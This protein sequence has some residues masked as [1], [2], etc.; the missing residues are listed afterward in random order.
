MMTYRFSRG[1]TTAASALA[2]LALALPAHA[3]N[4][5]ESLGWQFRT[6]A[7]RVNQAAI[8]DLIEKRKAGSYAAPVY[9][10]TIER[11][12]N[13]GISSTA[14]GNADTQTALANSPSVSGATATSTGNASDSGIAGRSDLASSTD[15]ANS[16][17]IA[18][19]VTGDSIA[20]GYGSATQALN[21][22]Q[23]NSGDQTASVSSSTACKFGALN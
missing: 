3:N 5:G 16:G 18:A 11:Q 22:S 15:Q 21:S 14:T 9:Q 6:S 17:S 8:L 19:G 20:T 12:F 13:C 23:T 1:A 7:D 4:Y 2:C 10:T